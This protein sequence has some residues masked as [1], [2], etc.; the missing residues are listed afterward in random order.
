MKTPNWEVC[1]IC[2]AEL[3][4]E[5]GKLFLSGDPH[6]AP[7]HMRY[8]V[9]LIRSAD[10]TILVDTGFTAERA[11]ARQRRML[12]CPS[13][14]LAALGVACEDIDTVVITHMHFDHAGN[15]PL[16][17][18]ARFVLQDEEMRFATGRDMALA[19]TRAPFE[20][21]DVQDM[22]ALNWAQ[23]VDWVDGSK[24]IAP[25]VTVTAVPGH[26]KGLQVVTV[27]LADGPLV[28]ASDATHLWC[29][30]GW[31]DPFPVLA[32]LNRTL[33]G[34]QRILEL[35]EGRPERLIPG[36]DPAVLDLYP[37]HPHDCGTVIVSLPALGMPKLGGNL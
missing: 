28:L 23:R 14:G 8:Y 4:T 11:K 17:S 33:S 16:F 24:E 12:R 1:A 27:A 15:L 20:L 35:A 2:Y 13:E 19:S 31:R 29:N 7:G 10:R 34:H 36:H 18:K 3:H 21:S 37:R 26:S 30:I 25:G 9:W 5:A 32:D 6:D 22:L